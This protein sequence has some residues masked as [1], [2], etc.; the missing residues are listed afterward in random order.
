[1]APRRHGNP[2]R[3]RASYNRNG[4]LTLVP[5]P[6]FVGRAQAIA[7]VLIEQKGLPTDIAAPEFSERASGAPLFPFG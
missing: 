6:R 3:L 4:G 1:M 2:K 7:H 5:L